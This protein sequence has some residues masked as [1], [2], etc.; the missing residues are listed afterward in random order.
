MGGPIW[1]API[2]H[3]G[4]VSDVLTLVQNDSDKFGT[5]KRIEGILGMVLEEL[6]EVP[7][8]YTM[9]K[10]CSTLHIHMMPMLKLRYLNTY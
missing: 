3:N 10:I 7:L 9:D 5:A 4:F 2:H 8:Y 6:P 1:T